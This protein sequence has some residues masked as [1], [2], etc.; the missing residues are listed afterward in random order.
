MEC[1]FF[2]SFFFKKNSFQLQI[3]VAQRRR[4]AWDIAD[5]V[6]TEIIQREVLP[7]IILG[8]LTDGDRSE[9]VVPMS[10]QRRAEVNAADTIIAE[11]V[12]DMSLWIIRKIW[13]VP[14]FSLFLLQCTVFFLLGA[15]V[16]IKMRC[17][18]HDESHF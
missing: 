11:V 12:E 14:F 13:F 9:F 5:L 8:L 16:S 1:R 18:E 17:R 7:D 6:I 10:G 15:A 4:L 2:S 3:F